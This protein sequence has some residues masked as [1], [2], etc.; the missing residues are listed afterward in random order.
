MKREI[1]F[2]KSIYGEMP[3]IKLIPWLKFDKNVQ[4]W[5]FTRQCTI[6]WARWAVTLVVTKYSDF[7][8]PRNEAHEMNVRKYM[9][10]S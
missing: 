8:Q 9:Q 5:A 1:N 10:K 6:T 7:N 3:L 2:Y 4:G